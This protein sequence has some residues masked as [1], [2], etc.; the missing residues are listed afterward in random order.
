MTYDWTLARAELDVY[1]FTHLGKQLT[2]AQVAFFRTNLLNHQAAH[3]RQHG[4]ALLNAYGEKEMLRNC[5]RFGQQY[6]DLVDS[7]WLNTFI[8]ATLNDRAILHGYHGILTTGASNGDQSLP[9]RFHR[10]AP[11]FKDIRTCVLL[12]MPLV[13]FTTSVGP[14]EVVPSTHLFE[15]QPTQEFMETHAKPMLVKAGH[16]FA[17][18][19]A[20][21]HRASRN[22]S[23]AVRPLLQMNITAAFMKQQV[24]VWADDTFANASDRV[25]ARLGYNVRA[26][27]DPDEMLTTNR[28]W[29]SGNYDLANCRIK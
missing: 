29:K 28:N 22:R 5:G 27:K 2:D 23:G 7:E 8:N 18:D 9:L 26:Y 1:G 13:D 20:L 16:V 10:D 6:L 17:M 25:K 12:L 11:W 3:I 15:G 24:D 14:T 4:E 19:G 21:W